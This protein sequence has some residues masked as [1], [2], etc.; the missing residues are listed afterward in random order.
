LLP[1]IG[2]VIQI[3][4]ESAD[5]SQ[6]KKP[7]KSRIAEVD[8]RFFWIEAPIDEKGRFWTLDNGEPLSVSFM[9]NGATVSFPTKVAGLHK[10]KNIRFYFI[11]KPDPAQIT[12]TQR[13][14][15]LRVETELDVAVRLAGNRRLLTVTRDISGGGMSI[16]TKGFVSLLPD[17]TLDC[18]VVIPFRNGT[19]EHIQVKGVVVRTVSLGNEMLIMINFKD[20]AETDRQKIIK[21]CLDRQIELRKKDERREDET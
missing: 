20:I 5:E 17:D 2:Q 16:V 14:S 12:R 4:L 21:Y 15:Y 10:E 11:E 19:I 8:E 3:Q 13:R 9:D 1:N 18:W 7:L 6:Q